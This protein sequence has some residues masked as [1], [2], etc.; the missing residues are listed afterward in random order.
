M[1][2]LPKLGGLSGPLLP[3]HTPAAHRD[4]PLLKPVLGLAVQL[5]TCALIEVFVYHQWTT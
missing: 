4:G 5:A 3:A 1:G 2:G